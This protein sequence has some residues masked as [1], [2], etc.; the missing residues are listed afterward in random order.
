[1]DHP[2]RPPGW[3]APGPAPA[4]AGADP[5]LQ[6]GA[7]EDLA[8]LAGDWRLF[9]PR[10]GH[11]W[12]LDDLVTA[13][14]ALEAAPGA[15]DVIDLGCGLGSV[16]LLLAWRLPAATLVG[17]E[18]QAARAARA[19]RSIRF[20]GVAGRCRVAE[21]D[22]R[23]D[24]GAVRAMVP[25]GAALVTGTPPYFPPG[26]ATAAIDDEAAAC[27]IEARG[28]VEAYLAAAATL[29]APAGTFVMCFAAPEEAR[30]AAAAARTGWAAARRRYIIPRLGKPALIVVEAFTR[31]A[32][33]TR[34]DE[35]VVRDAGCQWTP[36]F[37]AVRA[38][39]GMPTRP[40]R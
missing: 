37:A 6:P 5:D 23:A 15:S 27:R 9:Q 28:G 4:G 35:L 26:T 12:S 32:Q 18:A 7:D 38:R 21:G 8:Y 17:L 20:N 24:L 29:A 22:L 2:R 10:V 16:L 14:L 11:R 36:A 3:T 19:R 39:F 13:D 25:A 40:P 30:V 34:C 31:V 33:E 1:M